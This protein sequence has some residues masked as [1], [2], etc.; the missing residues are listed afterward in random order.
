MSVLESAAPERPSRRYADRWKYPELLEAGYLVVPSDFLRHYSRLKPHALTHAEALFVLH[1][2]EFKWDQAA[3]FPSY[4]KLAGR[5]GVTVKMARRY[6][7][8][9]ERK[10]CLHRM[11]RTGNTNLFDL[12]PLFNKLLVQANVPVERRLADD[13]IPF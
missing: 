3:P 10:G 9:L 6:A 5:M 11:R 13:T 12:T 8:N 1:L 7:Q 2:M 4:A